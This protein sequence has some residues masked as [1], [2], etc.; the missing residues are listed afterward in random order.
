VVIA[1]TVGGIPEII[2]DGIDGILMQLDNPNALAEALLSVCKIRLFGC[3]SPI[4]GI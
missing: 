2:K 3:P 1:T 4:T